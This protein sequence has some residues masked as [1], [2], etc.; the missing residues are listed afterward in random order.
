MKRKIAFYKFL[1][2]LCFLGLVTG[3]GAQTVVPDSVQ[4]INLPP[5]TEETYIGFGKQS[6]RII[7]SAIS[8]VKGSELRK[9]FTNSI[10][11]TLAGRL[12][13][14]TVNVG[15]NDPG[16]AS[17]TLYVRGINT[18]GFSASPLI[19]I[20][21]FLGDYTQLVPEEIEEIS[22]LKDAS[23]TAVYGMRGANGVVQVTTKKGHRGPLVVSFTA[24][25]GFQKPTALPKFLDA[26]NYAN[27]YNEALANDGKPALYSQTDLDHYRNGTDPVFHPN[28]NWYKEV[29]RQS[30]PLSNYTLNFSGGDNTVRYFLLLNALGSEGLY[31]KF[32]NDFDESANPVYNRYNLRGNVDVTLSKVFSAQLNIGGS[33]EDKK[34][35]GDLSTS[36]NFGLLDRLPPNAFPVTNPNGTF[37]GN[38]TYAGNPYANLTSTG[39]STSN[40]SVLQSSFKMNAALDMITKGL[41]ATAAVAFNN[42][43]EA[44]SNKRK[45]YVR[46]SVSKNALGDTVY[47]SFGQKTSLSPEESVLNQSQ[48]YSIQGF[49]NYNRTFGQHGITAMAMF[50][51]DNYNINRNYPNTD[52]A[53]QSFPFKT[54]GGA[55]RVT[56]VNK[57]RYIAEFSAGVTGTENFADG[58]R[59]GFFPAGSIGWIAS[60]ESF[61]KGSKAINFFKIRA[62]Y[63]LVGNEAIGG[64]RFMFA[65]RYPFGASYW[66]G[67]NNTLVNSISEGRRLNPDVTWE[68]EKKANIGI[69]ANLFN[70][71][72]I[73]VDVFK[74]NRYDILASAAATLPS[75]L[76]FNGLPDLNIGT[77]ENKGFEAT[78][79]YNTD[80]K[81][82][83]QVFAE[84]T[85]FYAKN[86]ITYRGEA[87]ELNQNL[88][89]TG[90]PVGQTFGL[91]ALG[92]FQSDAEIATS[93]KPL[94][95]SIKP[96][97]I[98]YQDIGGPNGVPDGVIDGNDVTAIGKS[99]TP[100]WTAGF[101]TGASFKG[102]D[103][104]LFF[105]GVTGV[106]RSLGGSRYYAFQNNGQIGEIALNRWTPQTA[107]TADYPRLSAN[108]NLNNYRG[109]S[110]WQRDASFIKLR[111][112]E[113]GYTLAT[114]TMTKIGLTQTRIFV[115]GTNLLTFDKIKEGDVEALYGYP[116]LRTVSLGVKVQL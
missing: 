28:V 22:V 102:F 99:E 9:P 6:K 33:I 37:G 61:L 62:S 25:Y 109:S 12:P 116:A 19:I 115:N 58:K 51:T 67:T 54:N 105:Q 103:I 3:A 69:E 44:G 83:F 74:N 43:Y 90:W 104:D 60:N 20:D 40:G 111:N 86:K 89:R 50:N 94:G 13:G 82:A 56:Y 59:Y 81:K 24:Q 5:G 10:A 27:L 97:D 48:N 53:N 113:I 101:H 29:L 38:G 45:S 26:F 16:S 47:T 30:A 7:T 71:I 93:A 35:P 87:I 11:N 84:A 49:L 15:S 96:G 52:V 95:I 68:K 34:N 72:G 108:N 46:S 39:F 18:Y 65:Q 78:L 23:A 110:F 77:V 55:A 21:G 107:A 63:G 42:Y 57:D 32:G 31:K 36:A 14:L 64:Q 66:F 8:T 17:P 88:Y 41:S 98:R 2:A 70:H 1:P 80:V 76:G 4:V 106:S 92:L 114:K 85:V 100:E 73:V 79:R 75:F 91:Q 112:A